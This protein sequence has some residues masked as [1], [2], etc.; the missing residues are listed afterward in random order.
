MDSGRKVNCWCC[1]R[2]ST[3][4]SSCA[5]CG[6]W[7]FDLDPSH[8]PGSLRSLLPVAR[9]WGISDDGYRVDAVAEASRDDLQS[10]LAAMD[11]VPEDDL[12]LWLCGPEADA[13]SPSM[14]YVAITC[15]TMAADQARLEL[16]HTRAF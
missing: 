3:D 8:V 4:Q 5:W 10:I 2:L 16:G 1:A 14:E 9:R 7:L 13:S 11:G 15:L 6:V 12:D